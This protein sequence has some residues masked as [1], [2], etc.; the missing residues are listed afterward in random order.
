VSGDDVSDPLLHD[1][2]RS[3]TTNSPESG[4]RTVEV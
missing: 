2:A 4:I 1:A 3:A